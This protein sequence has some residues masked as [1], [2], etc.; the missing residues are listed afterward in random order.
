M[1]QNVLHWLSHNRLPAIFLLLVVVC[2]LVSPYFLTSENIWVLLRQITVIG[3]I[4]I[5]MTF[6]ILTAG[7]D[8]SVGSVV[9]LVSVVAMSAQRFG[10]A[11]VL[12]TGLL[13]G[14]AAGLSNGLLIAYGRVVPFLTTLAT[15]A[16][17]RG[18]ALWYT[19]ENPIFG[20]LASFSELGNGWI[21]FGS[22]EIPIPVICFAIL[23]LCGWV[24]LEKTLFGKYVR[25]IGSNAEAARMSGVN[26]RLWTIVTY[27]YCGLMTGVAGLIIT[28]RM[29]TGSPTVGQYYELDAI[30]SVIIGGTSLFGGRG[31]LIGTLYGVLIF[32]II[33]N[34]MN[35]L[36]WPS[37]VK[38]TIR[39]VV[40]LL[41]MMGQRDGDRE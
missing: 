24:L 22:A 20:Q 15:M 27:A 7:I 38:Y 31:S 6:V 4:S 1:K 39:G 10:F 33:A 5:G 23:F 19:N 25:A 37:H 9:A 34:I 14:C 16:I 17:A 26:L 41:A 18:L 36:N 8:L 28:A 13:V 12:V 29:N 21:G 35:L 11:A 40:I 30:A 3:T 2:S 32:G